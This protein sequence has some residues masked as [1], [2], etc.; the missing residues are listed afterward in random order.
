MERLIITI[1]PCIHTSYWLS[2]GGSGFDVPSFLLSF[3]FFFFEEIEI[4]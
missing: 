3:P 4:F 2:S 1:W